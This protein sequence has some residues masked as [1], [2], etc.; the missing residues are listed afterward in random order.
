[1]KASILEAYEK[2]LRNIRSINKPE[3]YWPMKRWIIRFRR[4]YE[5]QPWD[6]KYLYMRS[7]EDELKKKLDEICNK[8]KKRKTK[9]TNKKNE[10]TNKTRSVRNKQ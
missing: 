1:M 10:K 4:M 3:H 8:N 5:I 2:G 7:L 9:K 6:D